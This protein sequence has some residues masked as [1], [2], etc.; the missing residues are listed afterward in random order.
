ML[1]NG[2]CSFCKSWR[3]YSEDEAKIKVCFIS[4]FYFTVVFIWLYFKAKKPTG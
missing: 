4:V 1:V 2:I 3:R